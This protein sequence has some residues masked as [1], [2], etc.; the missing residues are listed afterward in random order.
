MRL[1]D[2]ALPG[3]KRRGHRHLSYPQQSQPRKLSLM[4]VNVLSEQ[5]VLRP[6]CERSQVPISFHVSDYFD[7]EGICALQ[8]PLELIS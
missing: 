3:W 7:S 2:A 8:L 6:S 4:T 1:P 5:A